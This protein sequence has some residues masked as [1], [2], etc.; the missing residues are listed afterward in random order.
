MQEM[1]EIRAEQEA[2]RQRDTAQV[3]QID[4]LEHQLGETA[5]ERDDVSA[6][7]EDFRSQVEQER[8]VRMC[9]L[10]A[11]AHCRSNSWST[12]PRDAARVAK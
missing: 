6:Q 2:N 5:R 11:L 4:D 9:T 1:A 7:M 12:S 8:Q 3:A 10:L